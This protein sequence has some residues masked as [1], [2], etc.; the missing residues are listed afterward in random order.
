MRG[1]RDAATKKE[2]NEGVSLWF[3]PVHK[4]RKGYVC[5]KGRESF[6]KEGVAGGMVGLWWCFSVAI[7]SWLREKK[8][9]LMGEGGAATQGKGQCVSWFMACCWLREKDKRF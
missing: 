6:G 9:L 3:W 1:R 2:E 5:F 8:A 7:G 4:E